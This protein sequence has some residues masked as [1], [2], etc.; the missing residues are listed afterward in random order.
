MWS[1]ALKMKKLNASWPWQAV[2]WSSFLHR[3]KIFPKRWNLQ[4]HFLINIYEFKSRKCENYYPI[5]LKKSSSLR[6]LNS[7]PIFMISRTQRSYYT[8]NVVQE[9]IS[10]EGENNLSI[11]YHHLIIIC[12]YNNSCC[13]FLSLF[14]KQQI[15]IV[16]TSR[17]KKNCIMKNR[18]E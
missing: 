11:F 2:E 9:S 13:F 6:N 1:S 12:S 8:N 14:L 4:T 5:S 7:F 18:I 10:K 15:I 16:K 3:I 17:T